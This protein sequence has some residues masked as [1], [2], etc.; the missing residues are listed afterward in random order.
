MKKKFYP[1]DAML[2]CLVT[3]CRNIMRGTPTLSKATV[4][5]NLMIG[6]LNVCSIEC[7]KKELI[8]LE[9]EFHNGMINHLEYLYS[10]R[11]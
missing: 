10:D 3:E 4:C 7:G 2:A 11:G 8:K 6:V 5:Y 1:D 9:N